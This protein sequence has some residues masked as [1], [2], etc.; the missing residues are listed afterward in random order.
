MVL[1]DVIV[2]AIVGSIFSRLFGGLLKGGAD[3]AK[4]AAA[5]QATTP[6]PAPTATS[7][8]W[9]TSAETPGGTEIAPVKRKLTPVPPGYIPYSPTPA[10]VVSRARALLRVM[11]LGQL[12]LEPDPVGNY[13]T[14]AYRKEP[15]AA[16]KT[17]I[18]VYRPTKRSPVLE[19]GTREAA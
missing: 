5:E 2:A 4:R 10:A 18:T 3:A 9:P 11:L 14:I 7:A 1:G 12:R 6:S 15:H 8:P 13:G 19:P 17:G 16:G